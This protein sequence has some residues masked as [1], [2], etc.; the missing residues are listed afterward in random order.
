MNIIKNIFYVVSHYFKFLVL[1]LLVVCSSDIASKSLLVLM[2]HFLQKLPCKDN[3]LTQTQLRHVLKPRSIHPRLMSLLE[4]IEDSMES[5]QL[6]LFYRQC[7]IG[8]KAIIL[9]LRR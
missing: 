9:T 1:F 5:M 4:M 6:C 8:F 2:N 3:L 7:A